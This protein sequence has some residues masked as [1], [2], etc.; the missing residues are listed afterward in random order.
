VVTIDPDYSV[1]LC[2]GTHVGNTGELG[3]CIITSE[4]SVAAGVRRIEAICS[5]AT[6]EYL[7]QQQN[8][9]KQVSAA[10]KNPKDILKSIEH[11]VDELAQLKK[12]L[13]SAESRLLGF[14][15][16]ELI[17]Q[18]EN[19]D[20]ISFLGAKVEVTSVDALKKLCNE[21]RT[22]NKNSFVV[23]ASVIDGKPSVAI[24]IEDEL[25]KSSSLDANA[26]IK[27][28]VAKII[29]GGGG[30]Q[31]SLAIAGGQD[32]GALTAAITAVKNALHA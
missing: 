28:V 1:E 9:M 13:E 31:K 29:N 27:N 18:F 15:K 11:H 7:T 8:L 32:A 19:I 16:N 2:G 4:S 25:Q 12:Q 30:G 26:F 6:E 3:H 23:L 24:G 21:L 10:L 17:Q 20:Q 5:I 22:S 14:L